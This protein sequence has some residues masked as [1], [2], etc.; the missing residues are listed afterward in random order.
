[1]RP[2]ADDSGTSAGRTAAKTLPLSSAEARA[3]WRIVQPSWRAYS[4]STDSIGRIDRVAISLTRTGRRKPTAEMI[5]SFAAASAPS[6]SSEG[7]ASAYPARWASA[8]TSANDTGSA[9]MRLDVIA[10]A[11]Q[12]A[13]HFHEAVAGE[14][15]L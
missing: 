10:G 15:F 2:N 6:R 14:P 11:V 7:S 4:K 5:A 8:S 1:L 13:A 9:C 3:T 12:D